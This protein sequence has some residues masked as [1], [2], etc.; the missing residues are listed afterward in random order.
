MASGDETSE[1]SI[2]LNDLLSSEPDSASA[3]NCG[4]VF[5]T[6]CIQRC[7]ESSRINIKVCP[8]CRK[9]SKPLKLFLGYRE[10]GCGFCDEEVMQ[11]RSSLD[12]TTAKI[13]SVTQEA[14]EAKQLVN[15]LQNSMAKQQKIV[16]EKDIR[17]EDMKVQL[18]SAQDQV[19]S[20][21][22]VAAMSAYSENMNNLTSCS[23][24]LGIQASLRRAKREIPEI[25]LITLQQR[26]LDSLRARLTAANAEIVSLHQKRLD[27]AEPGDSISTET[28][29]T[30][31]SIPAN[32][33]NHLAE[34]GEENVDDVDDVEEEV[35]NDE[36][37]EE[38]IDENEEPE[39]L[40]NIFRPTPV[41]SAIVPEDR[42]DTACS[43]CTYLNRKNASSC[44]VSFF[45][46]EIIQSFF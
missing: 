41:E 7:S 36:D 12:S 10:G 40:E 3:L 19:K 22:A 32:K 25:D 37:M 24:G 17:I 44:K 16:T 38:W 27:S 8:L 20:L 28:M 35:L 34:L 31:K 18:Q 43:R 29:K 45:N 2:C 42:S 21:S 9:E 39:P 1:C 30:N 11:L 5:H 15:E 4:H 14:I 6:R 13:K 23:S 26:L 33:E 46:V